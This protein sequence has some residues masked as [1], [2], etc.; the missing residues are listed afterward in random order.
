M[1]PLVLL[2]SGPECGSGGVQND[3][4]RSETVFL[5]RHSRP[6]PV[7]ENRWH[8]PANLNNL[9]VG[10]PVRNRKHSGA[11]AKLPERLR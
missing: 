5:R 10:Y 2:G 3:A 6:H 1:V 11:G 7:S 8:R 4:L 9:N